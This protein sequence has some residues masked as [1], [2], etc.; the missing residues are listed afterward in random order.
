MTAKGLVPGRGDDTAGLSF[1][2]TQ[3]SPAA[4]R[5]DRERRAALGVPYPIRSN[6]LVAE[7]TYQAQVVPGF[8]LQPDLQYVVRPGG[9]IPDPLRAGYR[10]IA[11]AA[12]LGIRATIVY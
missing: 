11:D 2:F 5:T 9:G 10:P 4:Q 8:T 12:V 7:A 1:A 3:I 6:E